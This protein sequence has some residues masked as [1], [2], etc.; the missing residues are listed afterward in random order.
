MAHF[1]RMENNVCQEVIVVNNEVL[2]LAERQTNAHNFLP[3]LVGQ[4]LEDG[5]GYQTKSF[6]QN[7]SPYQDI[8]SSLVNAS[9][10]A[11]RRAVFDRMAYDPSRVNAADINKADPVARI[12]MRPAAYGK[13]PADA[14]F[15]FPFR[16]DKDRKSTR[17]N[18]SHIPLSRMP[19]SA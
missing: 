12:A 17:L 4:P 9:M 13:N 14:F 11:R 7:I 16:D 1:A 2:I 19:S 10:Y 8:G 3:I 5:L 6:A 15:Q 18:S